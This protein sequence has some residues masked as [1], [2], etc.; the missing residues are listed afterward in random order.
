MGKVVFLTVITIVVCFGATI[1][2]AAELTPKAVGQNEWK[3]YTERGDFAGT[4]K[5]TKDGTFRLYNQDGDY[6][7]AIIKSGI[8]RPAKRHHPRVTPEA[9]QLYLDALKAIEKIK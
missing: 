8:W 7:G 1:V 4:L 5:R 2:L 3:M 6:A 9:A